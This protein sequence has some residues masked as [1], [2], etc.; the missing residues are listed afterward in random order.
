MLDLLI[1][2]GQAVF[3]KNG[4]QKVDIGVRNGKIEAILEPGSEVSARKELDAEGL[5]IFP[6][7]IDAHEHLGIY[8]STG[9]DFADTIGHAV[10]GVTTIVNYYREP[11]SYF[12]VIPKL[13]EEAE[14]HSY[15]DFA[16]SMGILTNQHIRE[17]EGYIKE[18]GQTS[19]KF[20]RNYE[21]RVKEVF[22]TDDG[23]DLSSAD[24]LHILQ[25]FKDISPK[26][27]LSVHC[28]NMDIQ[29]NLTS[30][31]KA[32]EMPDTLETW[33]KTSPGF[34]EAESLLSTLYMNEQVGGNV[35][36]VHLTSGASVNAL[37]H[38]PWL[39]ERG[40]KV[41]TCTHY[42]NLTT[43][44]PCGLKA[45]VGPPIHH[46]ED[47]DLLWQGI[48]EGLIQAIGTDH[49]P[50]NLATKFKKG[51]GVWDTLFGFPSAGTLLP[52]MIS[53]GHHQHELPLEKIADLTSY[54]LAES[55][56]L[57]NKGD[58]AIGKDAD[59]AI[60]DINEE[61]TVAPDMFH[62]ACDY[63]IFEGMTFKGW[64]VHTISR[65]DFL[66]KDRAPAVSSPRGK[67]I[68]RTL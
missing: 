36:L 26:M 42:L 29:R 43:D 18:F 21:R 8:N 61:R 9:E 50:T 57:A 15:I 56:N 49:C 63:S 3:P 60:V 12:Q 68:K 55:F 65:G 31:L 37:K 27:L 40:M 19:F 24:L 23:I 1:K 32:Q 59:F 22:K 44:S 10:G 5:H 46:Q 38:T 66:V 45:K 30:Q 7:V 28:E 11:E 34:A 64:P 2:N 53:T 47:Q 4:V 17:L 25:R 58:I 62:S 67:Y 39:R 51:D 6:G 14:K 13:I 20:F 52:S 16:Y 54:Q 48:K 33:S 35:F 41:E